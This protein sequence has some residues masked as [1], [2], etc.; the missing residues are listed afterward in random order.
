R[1]AV[2]ANRHEFRLV[3]SSADVAPVLEYLRD[4]QAIHRY[5]DFFVNDG[6]KG[7]FRQCRPAMAT[8]EDALVA[9]VLEL[10]PHKR[11]RIALDQGGG[12]ARACDLSTMLPGYTLS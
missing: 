10:F 12:I 9:A 6:D 1:L 5:G 4:P 2:V 3:V 7:L 8:F 11:V